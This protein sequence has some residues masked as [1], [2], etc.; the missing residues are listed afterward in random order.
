MPA[1]IASLPVD[2]FRTMPGFSE[3]VMQS[4]GPVAVP[5]LEPRQSK[6]VPIAAAVATAA[7]AT[8]A[9]GTAVVLRF[10]RTRAA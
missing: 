10:R 6:V 4:L 7:V 2:E 5:D 9:A 3:D 1:E 8:D